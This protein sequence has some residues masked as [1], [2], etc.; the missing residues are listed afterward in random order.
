M[1]NVDVDSPL[2]TYN[3]WLTG[4]LDKSEVK[5]SWVSE[6]IELNASDV[7][8]GTRAIFLRDDKATYWVEYR[9]ALPGANY[10]PGLAIF[11][12]DPPARNL[13]VSPNPEDSLGGS[14][15][16]GISTDYWMLNWDN[17]TYAR[18]RAAGSMTL[19]QGSVATSFSGAISIS[20]T[21]TDSDKKV[22]VN[23]T[24]KADTTPP[25]APEI[26]DASQWRYPNLSIIKAGYDDGESAIAGFEID[27][28]GKVSAVDSGEVA[29][30]APS[31][32]NPIS[33]QKTVYVRNLPEG[34]YTI[35]LRAIDVWGNKSA[36]SKSVKAYIDR[37]NPIVTKDFKVESMSATSTNLVWDGVRDEGIGLCSTILHNEEGFVL[38][39]SSAKSSPSFAIPTGEAFAAKAQVFDCLG[40]GMAGEVSFNSVLIDTKRGSRTGKWS[41]A[42][43]VYGPGALKCSGKCT[44]S[45]SVNGNVAVRIGEGS[46]EV[47]LAGKVVAKVPAASAQVIRNSDSIAIGDRGKVI[48]VTGTN[49]V[50]AGV[51]RFEA[52]VGEFKAITLGPEFP[53]P[54]LDDPIQKSMNRFGFNALDFTNDWT[55]LP[56]ARGT[57]LLDPTLDLCGATY[58]S[59]SGRE[60]RRQISVTKVDSPY[61]FLSSEAVKYR[62]VAAANAALT[63]LKKNF[64]TCVANKGGNE[65]GVFTSYSFQTIPVSKASLVD[66]ASRVIVRATIG[67]GT[68][69]R[70]LFGAYQFNGQFFTGLY[71]V[72][73]GEAAISD[74]EVKRWLDVAGVMAQRL[75]GNSSTS[76]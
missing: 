52:K 55:V 66:D 30:F 67:T 70:Q 31:Y 11:R 13:V 56:M 41:A 63:E 59:E 1:G 37:G 44:V 27:I 4:Y 24:R 15:G 75:K 53:D 34:D 57:T 22:I 5:Q 58:A 62:S 76:A 32:L 71:V 28:N 65:N 45:V 20:A 69:A 72:V 42:P 2:T 35:A 54:S 43:A 38:A 60:V 61:Q 7:A 19:P 9:R 68:A 26:I 14:P 46:A 74:A 50:Y 48:R 17:Y 16:E 49:F 8:G 33:P 12:T 3:Q 40:N 25:P 29:D 36:W 23:I 21:G 18:S 64:E 73:G 6:K 39:R 47:S 10:K 51:A